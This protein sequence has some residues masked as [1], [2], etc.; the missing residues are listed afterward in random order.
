MSELD[1]GHVDAVGRSSHLA[2]VLQMSSTT[3]R[4]SLFT[5]NF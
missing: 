5:C 1:G 4:E 3:G 2:P